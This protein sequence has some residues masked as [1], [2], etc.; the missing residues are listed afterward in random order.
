MDWLLKINQNKPATWMTKRYVFA[1]IAVAILAICAFTTVGVLIAE[2]KST[3]SLVNVAG[4]QRMLSQRT[5]MY[6]AF[7]NHARSETEF[8]NFKSELIKATDLLEQSH[9]A[10]S[11][12]GS[13]IGLTFEP[14]KEAKKRY[15]NVENPLNDQMRL[16]LNALKRI[17]NLPAD[18]ITND[19]PSVIYVLSIAPK[20]LL[21]SL[22]DMVLLYQQEGEEVFD[23]LKHLEGT[24]LSLTLL[25]LLG[26]AF[27]VFRPMVNHVTRQ[28]AQIK[29][30]SNEL[31][32]KVARRTNQLEE[33]RKI[34][35]KA[36]TAK[37]RFLAAAGHDIKQPL[38]AFGMFTG[39]L[40]KRIE[41]ERCMHILNDMHEAQRSMRSLLDSILSLS[42]LE[43]GVTVSKPTTFDVGPLL[44]QLTRE[45]R[46]HA[47]NKGLEL[48]HVPTQAIINTDPLLLERIIRN[49]LSN[50]IRYT[51]TGRVL[52]GCRHVVNGIHIEVWDTGM[53]ISE[54][55]ISRIFDEF[56]QLDDPERDRSEGIGLGLA[57]VKRLSALL[58]TPID[59][60]SIP[61]KGSKF[62][63]FIQLA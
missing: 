12:Q 24:F 54:D 35:E 45:Y 33:A 62:S 36:N 39:M 7:L 57:I 17:A 49:F 25:I 61:G 5:A 21:K 32:M 58:G 14:S 28:M 50:A 47:H 48:R 22:D 55:A 41:D 4:R 42:K 29:D 59:C 23:F 18:K 11:G 9:L 2:H 1:L 3:L 15:F 51:K 27:F 46:I 6:V 10:L 38:E 26:E 16:Y 53:G 8:A 43:A 60:K 63:V 20:D 30:F 37:S 40:E 44:M 52:L 13:T 19:H 34:A 56:S 31:E